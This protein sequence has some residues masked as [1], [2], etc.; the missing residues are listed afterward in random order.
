MCRRRD[1]LL[2]TKKLPPFIFK[3]QA[4]GGG[5]AGIKRVLVEGSEFIAVQLG[6]TG[7]QTCSDLR[8]FDIR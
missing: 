8:Q 4:R 3:Y 6:S 5:M 2:D 1:A 7:W